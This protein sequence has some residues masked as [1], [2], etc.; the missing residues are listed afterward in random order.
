MQRHL[1]CPMTAYFLQD[2][3]EGP[4]LPEIWVAHIKWIFL[5]HRITKTVR[6]FLVFSLRQLSRLFFHISPS[7]KCAGIL[8][9]TSAN[10]PKT[11]TMLLSQQCFDLPWSSATTGIAVASL[12]CFSISTTLGKRLHKRQ[13][14]HFSCF[15]PEFLQMSLLNTQIQGF[16]ATYFIQSIYSLTSPPNISP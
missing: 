7:P 6:E 2:P 8:Y 11:D 14:Q 4:Y 16:I 13:R 10:I 9:S 1:S 5:T 12:L 3:F 15:V